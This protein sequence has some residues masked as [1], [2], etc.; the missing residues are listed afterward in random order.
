[1]LHLLAW[2]IKMLEIILAD[3]ATAQLK[4]GAR[5]S[6]FHELIRA[7]LV[8]PPVHVGRSARFPMHELNALAAAR[9]AGASDSEIRTLVADLVAQRGQIFAEWRAATLA[10]AV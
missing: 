3:K 7:G 5:S 8:T 9:M 4:I 1:M 2:E 6:K 10:A